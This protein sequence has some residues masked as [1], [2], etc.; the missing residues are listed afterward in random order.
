MDLN[1]IF[2]YVYHLQFAL[3][4]RLPGVPGASVPTVPEA[5]RKL[6]VWN[7]LVPEPPVLNLLPRMKVTKSFAESRT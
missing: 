2:V 5:V 6:S 7:P 3:T 1:K 4:A